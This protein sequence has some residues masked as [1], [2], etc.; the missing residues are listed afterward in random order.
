MVRPCAF[1]Y[2]EHRFFLRF[3]NHVQHYIQFPGGTTGTN[4]GAPKVTGGLADLND[5][6][7]FAFVHNR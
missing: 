1:H 4:D 6:C 3:D 2:H 7:G 5:T